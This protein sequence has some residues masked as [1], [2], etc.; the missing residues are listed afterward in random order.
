MALMKDGLWSIVSG[1]E[2]PPDAAEADKYAKFV[3]RR[4]RALAI[5]VLSIEPSLLYLIGDPEDPAIVWQKLADQ[6]QKKTWANKLELRRKLYS[7]RLKGGSSVQEHIKSMTEIFD[8]LSVIGDP[9]SEEDRVVQLLASLPESYSMLVTALEANAEVPKMEH[10]TER[11]LHEE[12]KLKDR[13]VGDR[14]DKAM[15]AKHLHKKGPKCHHCGKYGHIRRNCR[16][17]AAE[18]KSDSSEKGNTKSVKQHANAAEVRGDFSSSSNS[19]SDSEA[20]L[21]T[22]HALT[23]SAGRQDGWIVDSGATCHMSNDRRLFVELRDLEKPLEVTLGDGHDLNAIGRGVVVLQTKLPSGRTKKCKLHDVLYVPKLS[24][25]LLSVSKASDAGKKVRFGE[26]SCQILD[27]NQKLIA[28]ATRAGDLYYLN[29]CPGFQRSHV[30]VDKSETMEDTWHRRF[31]HLG[32]RNLQK[33]AKHRMVDGFDFDATKQIK[34][35]ESCVNGKHHR[36]NFPTSGGKRSEEPLGLV[37]SDLCGKMSSESLSGAEYFLTFIDDRTRYVWVYILKRKDQVFERFLEWKAL[38]EKSTGRKLKALR[39]D[40]GGEYTSA[41]FEAYLRKGVRHELTVPKAPEQNGVAERMNRTLVETMRSMLADSKMPHRFWAEALSTA[42]YLRNRS[43]TKSVNGMTPFEA[44]TGEKPNVAH[45]RTFGC[46]VYVHIPKDERKKLDMKTKK[47]VLLGYG[48][49]TK[50]YRVYDPVRARV[51]HSR[52]VIFNEK[53]RGLDE[54]PKTMQEEKHYVDIECHNE[55]LA[56]EDT[57]PVQTTSQEPSVSGLRRSARNR[58]PPDFYGIRVNVA[59]EVLNEP[60]SMTEAL[61]SPDK[62]K[63]TEA[64]E[65]EMESLHKNDVWDLVML[66][67]GRKAVGSKWVFKLKVGPDGMVH[68]HKA[69][70]VA[71]GFSQKYGLDY[72]E[73]FSPVVRFESLRTVIGLA[74]QNGLKLHQMDVTTAFLNGELDEEVY[75][76]QPEGFATK[77]QEDLVCKL[78]RSIYGLKQSPRCWNSALDNQLKRMGF[79]QAKGDP[80]IYV[81]SEGEMFII[82]VYVDDIV[83][84]GK[85]KK[86]M[87]EVKQALAKQFEVKDMGELHYFLGVNIVQD[88]NTG[89]VC[90]GQPA[91][92]AN[93]VQKFGMEHAKAVNTPVDVS[94]KLIKASVEDECV[95]QKRYQSAVGSLLYLSTATRPDITYAVSNVAKYSAN[96]TKQH[97]TAVKRIFR[98]LKGT[99]NYG[100]LFSK[101]GS[102]DCVGFSDADWGGDH[103]DRKSTSGYLFQLSGAAISWRSKKQTSV[104]L[105]TAEAEYIA[106]ASAAQE[107]LWL[108][109]LTT[110]LKHE[111][112]AATVIFEDNQSTISMA[113]NPQFHG[114]SKHIAIKYHFIREQVCNNTVE[115]QYCRTNDMIAD[116]LTKGLHAEQFAK[117]RRMAGVKEMFQHPVSK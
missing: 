32:A 115:L 52:D 72:D 7:L 100:L 27:E 106:L 35:C 96:P 20:G 75:M 64:M 37:H 73:T 56:G 97:W 48:T 22:R 61:A 67:K 51:L 17:F 74:V 99:L 6:F 46:T 54:G 70:L 112:A 102:A 89:E 9:V 30:T 29:C 14:S 8:A 111:P 107:A 103:D 49:E 18:A 13:G 88:S 68:R 84:A 86:R 94:M 69:R 116:M 58:Q 57:K 1:S 25:N 83:L 60:T 71:Q 26:A 4:D 93:L 33:L 34:F 43:P 80:C 44:W 36:S 85:S 66:P 87:S 24:H 59:S 39:T 62:V 78:K 117:L 53:E 15:T 108:R 55:E 21:V 23:T 45:L 63:W 114:R 2:L 98:Y 47:C 38:V 95:D 79:V 42:V 82:A 76:K 101:E 12:Q 109:Q 113:K 19:D 105:S 10:V 16:K 28:V 92:A 3:A 91:Y 50:G 5:V 40:N 77:G 31:G 11:L 41:E 104:A 65:K 110:D 81:A 90:I